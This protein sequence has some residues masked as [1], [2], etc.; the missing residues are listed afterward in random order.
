MVVEKLVAHQAL[1]V[2]ETGISMNPGADAVAVEVVDMAVD[3]RN[4]M[5]DDM[6]I[7]GEE[8]GRMEAGGEI[9]AEVG[10]LQGEAEVLLGAVKVLQRG[11]LRSSNGIGN[12]RKG[13]L[14]K[15]FLLV[16]PLEETLDPRLEERQQP[17]IT[18]EAH[19]SW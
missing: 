2:M 5:I 12:V 11:E 19:Y 7:A 9:E 17:M 3:T 6:M 1:A 10:L 4:G 13:R 8:V 16:L 15:M 14:R 18:N